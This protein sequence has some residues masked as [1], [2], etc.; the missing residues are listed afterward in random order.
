M[1]RTKISGLLVMGMLL[2][3]LVTGLATTGAHAQDRGRPDH[4]PGTVTV[5]LLSFTDF[6]GALEPVPYAGEKVG[7]AAAVAGWIHK[8]SQENRNTLV[9]YSGDTVGGS[10]LLSALFHD[11]P[12]VELM[13]LIGVDVAGVGNHEFDEGVAELRR[14]VDG[15]CHHT[16]GCFGGDGFRGADYP[17][18]AANVVDRQTG[19]PILPPYVVKR[20]QGVRIGFIGLTLEDTPS[21]V[22]PSAVEGL[23]FLD[24]SD[25]VSRYTAELQAQG[26]ESIVVLVHQGGAVAGTDPNG[27]DDPRG[28][29]FQEIEQSPAAVD[30][31]VAGHTLSTFVCAV[32]G[33]PVTMAGDKGRFVTE[34]D[35][36]IDRRT[37]DVV[38]WRATNHLTT[39]EVAPDPEAQALVDRYKALVG[40]TL[41]RVVGAVA[42]PVSL[43]PD[44]SGE[45]AMGN[46]V[47]DSQAAAVPGASVAF[48]NPGGLVAE[49]DPGD[50]TVGEVFEA[51]PYGN[52]LVAMDLTGEQILRLLDEQWCDQE[53]PRILQVSA[54]LEY[55]WR[56]GASL[57]CQDRV[58]D[59]SVR[60]A[61]QPLDTTESYRIVTNNF[62]ASG[63][64]GFAVFT[65]GRDAVAAA[66]AT[67]ALADY[68][69]DDLPI[70]VPP[71]DRIDVV[72]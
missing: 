55:T 7:G 18:L 40:D 72:D 62:L 15:G 29:V 48:M 60:L 54:A 50:V 70:A 26:V 1:Q 32:D 36:V 9:A 49:L 43:Q 30:A 69:P 21:V 31:W 67:D 19:E 17:L 27:C 71:L 63:G 57:A 37:K 23:R 22:L 53:L 41:E 35:L 64:D 33:D 61:G 24:E 34:L 58:I 13:N 56:G 28:P 46:L 59:S 6:L 14:M 66:L 3:G 65:E 47:A 68:L 38:D 4:P 12:T 5:Q 16:D 51:L 52:H 2:T 11:E 45:T 42:G 20:V 8:L 10:P 39:H 44:D 25:T